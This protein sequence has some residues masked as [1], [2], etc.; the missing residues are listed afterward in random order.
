MTS[1]PKQL[2]ETQNLKLSEYIEQLTK[3]E[4][5]LIEQISNTTNPQEQDKLS[6][7]LIIIQ[8]TRANLISTLSTTNQYYTHNLI[9]SSN[10]LEQQTDAVAI[11][12]KEMELAKKRL[13][14]VNEQKQDKL[15]IVEINQYYSASYAEWT[16][17]VKIIIVTLISFMIVFMIKKYIPFIP[18]IVNSILMFAISIISI[19]YIGTTLSSI[20][21]R[22]NM[23]YDEYNWKFNVS[24][25]PSFE[26]SASYPNPFATTFMTCIGQNCCQ[27]GTIWNSDIGK[28]VVNSAS[29]SASDSTCTNTNGCSS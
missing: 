27:T 9:G 13:A 25:A 6:K 26:P 5:E 4:Q 15:R 28:C 29:D 16:R 3:S 18:S 17:L 7:L 1:Q 10:T 22:D 12:D 21:S 19:Y 24:Q 23:V 14:Y 2:Y 11:I 20:V 8:D